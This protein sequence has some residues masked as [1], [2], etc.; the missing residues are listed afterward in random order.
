MDFSIPA[1]L[2]KE[3][4]HFQEF[5]KSH[6]KSELSVWNKSREIPR[7]FFQ[8]LGDGNWYGLEPKNGELSKG[9]ALREALLAEAVAK[10]SP[11]VAVAILA[12]IDLGLSGVYL[13][14][15][16]PIR[17]SLCRSCRSLR[18]RVLLRELEIGYG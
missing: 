18:N 16:K 15:S 17:K 2:S 5:I 3:L 6:L 13:F 8:A 1:E 9:S 4:E 11:G 10:V 12:H 7:Q 14:G